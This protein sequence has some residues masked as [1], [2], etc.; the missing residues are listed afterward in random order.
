MV[1]EAKYFG[2]YQ[3]RAVERAGAFSFDTSGISNRFIT[4]NGDGRNDSV[5]FTFENQ[6][7]SEVKG[8]IFDM[9]GALVADM[10]PGPVANSLIWDAKSGGSPVAGGV[11]IYQIQGEGKTH[12]GTII[13]IK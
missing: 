3:L 2:Q 9:K 4:P 10:G 5:V 13:V 11:Y 12:N 6:R 1:L 7:D 8:R